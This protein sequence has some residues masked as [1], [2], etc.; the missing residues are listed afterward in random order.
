M[1]HIWHFGLFICLLLIS[2]DIR[3][4]IFYQ[5]DTSVKVFAYGNE[6]TIAWSGGFNNP[7]FSTADLNGDGLNDLVVFEPGLGVSTFLN[8]APVGSEPNYRYAPEYA[9]NFPACYSYLVMADYNCDGVADLFQRGGTGFSVYTG[10]YNSNHQLCFTYYKDLFYSNDVSTGGPANA[11]V[12]PGDIPAI[13][14][15]DG[16][17]DL[18]FISYYITGGYIYYYKNM[19]VEMGLPCDSIVIALKDRCWGKVYQG[20]F[21]AHTL[22]YSCNN[23]GLLRPSGSGEKTTHSGNTPCLFD[24]DMDGDMDYLDGSVSYNEMTF[25]KNGRIEQGSGPDSMISQDTLWQTGGKMI[26]LPV[27][28]TAYNIDVNQDGKKDLLISPNA[29]NGSEN[30]KCIWYY[31]NL[32]TPGVPN[33]QFQ[34]DSFLIDKTIDLGTASFPI[35]FDYDK[36]GKPDLIVG[37]D[38]YRQSS[39]VLSSRLSLYKNTSTPGNAS[40]TLQ[41]T[42]LIGMG[43][44]NFG[45]AAPATGDIDN[46]GLADLIV[47]HSDG[48]LSYYKNMA[49]SDAVQP[50]WQ[51][52][53]LQLTDIAGNVINTGGKAAPFIYDI[54]HDGK[55]D[56][57]IGGLY[58]YI[59]YYQNVSV[60]PGT[61]RLKLISTRLGKAKA[62]PQ[63]IFGNYSTPF[64]GKI[65]PSG[66]D[67]LLL[68]SNSGNIYEFTG[69][70]TGDTSATYTMLDS[71]YSFIDST[72]NAYNSPGHYN[73]IYGD[74]RSTLTVGDID[75]SGSY[76]MIVGNVKGGLE[77]YKRKVYIA[78]TS[79]VNETVKVLVYPNPAKDILYVS[80]DGFSHKDEVNISFY[81]LTGQ[82]LSA[83]SF[84]AVSGHTSLSLSALPNGVYVC[85]LQSGGKKYYSKFTVIR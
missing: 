85:L 78:E 5:H 84:P 58:G 57:I 32:S 52:T 74:R 80:W 82:Q 34:S 41:T 59:Q 11:F 37:S 48:T 45:G 43:A 38:G 53:A 24:W 72:N 31:K 39:G 7:Q 22:G 83:A 51:L 56:L 47:G 33:W 3:A 50:D 6:Q 9:L 60:S 62:D 23:T 2:N 65:D 70:Q 44:Q 27:W 66:N 81:N 68:G 73:G 35:L 14:D 76:S 13:V 12:N 79:T 28:P 26:E 20:F 17:G 21:R 64:I 4:Q 46:D 29:G 36:D 10:Y 61:I 40:F 69:F 8:Y 15:V 49:A 19:R 54:D 67:Y 18:D 42:D 16:D 63:Q 71:Q 30:Y 55:K 25:L 77:F 1:R 75:G